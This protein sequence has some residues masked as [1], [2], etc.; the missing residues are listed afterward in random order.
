M[1]NGHCYQLK[2]KASQREKNNKKHQGVPQMCL[3]LFNELQLPGP[4]TT[5]RDREIRVAA[6]QRIVGK[7]EKVRNMYHSG[8]ASSWT[9]LDRR[10][11]GP[12]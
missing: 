8:V 2:D 11:K 3:S 6:E 9:L 12:G 7:R 5:N 10:E 1:R 4:L